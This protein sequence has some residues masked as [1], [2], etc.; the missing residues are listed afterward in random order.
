MEKTSL[1]KIIIYIRL[2]ISLSAIF[3]VIKS[4]FV[5]PYSM[6]QYDFG[7]VVVGL[8]ILF[9]TTYSKSNQ[10][11]AFSLLSGLTSLGGIVILVMRYARILEDS[12]ELSFGISEFVHILI[13]LITA[14]IYIAWLKKGRPG[15]FPE[16]DGL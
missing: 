11:L 9:F 15:A 8:L 4:L 10:I 1:Q 12:G 3:I 6:N 5:L 7:V 16:N 13:V 2:T 14:G